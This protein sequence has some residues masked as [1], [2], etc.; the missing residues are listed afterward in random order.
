MSLLT[1]N[2]DLA[3]PLLGLRR[4][5]SLCGEEVFEMKFQDTHVGLNKQN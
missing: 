5:F 3:P 2:L 4:I 1:V